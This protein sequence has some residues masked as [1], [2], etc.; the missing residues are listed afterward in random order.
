MKRY[1]I[2]ATVIVMIVGAGVAIAGVDDDGGVINACAK[3]NNG[4]L[5]IVD[6]PEDCKNT[7]S[8]NSTCRHQPVSRKRIGWRIAALSWPILNLRLPGSV[9]GVTPYLTP[10]PPILTRNRP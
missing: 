10:Y 3:N 8:A 9:A 6:S 1:L 7:P 5:R 4:Q 2:I